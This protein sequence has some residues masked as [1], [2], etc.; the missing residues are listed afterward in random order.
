[1]GNVLILGDSMAANMYPGFQ[2]YL[3]GRAHVS[4]AASANCRPLVEPTVETLACA[5]RN[6]VVFRTGDISRYDLILIMGAFQSSRLIDQL[7]ETVRALEERGAR[8]VVVVGAPVRYRRPVNEILWHYKDSSADAVEGALDRFLLSTR[9]PAESHLRRLS[10]KHGWEFFS[11]IDLSCRDPAVLSSC[12]HWID[13]EAL[14]IVRDGGHPTPGG[15]S[16]FAK[17]FDAQGLFDEL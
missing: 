15:A 6:R 4:L 12:R 8:R 2:D 1:M 3:R 14:P 10:R 9:L 11:T 16:W 5:S 13:G 7:P 17:K